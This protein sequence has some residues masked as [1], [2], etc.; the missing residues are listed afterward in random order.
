MWLVENSIARILKSVSSH[1]LEW[2]NKPRKLTRSI[3][4]VSFLFL[5][6]RVI[7]KKSYKKEEVSGALNR[8]FIKTKKH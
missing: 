4:L 2:G 6:S 1:G 8:I 7:G 3:G 5:F